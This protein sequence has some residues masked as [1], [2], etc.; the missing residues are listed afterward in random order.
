MET[1]GE[2]RNEEGNRS[3][4]AALTHDFTTGSR[5]GQPWFSS[6]RHPTSGARYSFARLDACAA[7]RLAGSL[8]LEL[9]DMLWLRL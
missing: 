1:E 2:E 3:R 8:A 9:T 5:A 4:I 6:F 7:A